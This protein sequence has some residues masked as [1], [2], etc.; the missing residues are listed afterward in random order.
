MLYPPGGV[1]IGWR[2]SQVRE[3]FVTSLAGV[4][5]NDDDR[6]FTASTGLKLN[7]VH[8]LVYRCG[9]ITSMVAA[10]KM[11][12]TLWAER[13]V[14][15]LLSLP[16]ISEFVFRSPKHNAPTEKEVIDHLIV[17]KGD[18]ILISQKAQDDPTNRTA[19]KNELWVLNNI[20]DALKPIYRAIRKPDDRPKW[21]EHPR[22]GRVEFATLPRIIHAVALVETW[23]AVDL[24]DV[25]A[26]LPLE[27]LD[28]PITYMSINDFLNIVMQLRTVPEVL[29]Y[30]NA[31]RELPT[32]C[33]R[34]VGDELPFYELYIMN[35][36][37]LKGCMGHADARRAAYT[38]DDLLREALDRS[39]EYKFYSSQIEHI[40]DAL[41]Q[42]DPNYA[43]GLP[44]EVVALFD[45]QGER[46]NYL[47]LQEILTDM[48]LTERAMMGRQ[49]HNVAESMRGKTSGLTMAASLV[50]GRDWVFV[51][52]SCRGVEKPTRFG[53]AKTLAGG[54]LAHYQKKNCLVIIDRDGEH[55]DLM[56]SNPEYEPDA[57]DI[58]AGEK[59]FGH[60]R[61]KTVDIRRL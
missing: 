51:F 14:E 15:E 31:R 34:M 32:A 61:M 20:Q 38:H 25:A 18:G 1:W 33:L 12:R 22:R 37:S 57:A 24:K 55:Y 9:T 27:Y 10:P 56:L 4:Y 17:H 29:E 53:I 30:L 19:R 42:R 2:V 44:P 58:A 45:K 23:R 54:A 47:I 35:G 49:F 48:R 11:T 7:I 39:V 6:A 16:L 50:D 21:C 40:A 28:V 46:K 43:D 8:I 41:S 60:L 3:A 5:R 26:V 36:G 52:I 59:H 13:Q